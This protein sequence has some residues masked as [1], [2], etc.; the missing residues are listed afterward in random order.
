[1]SGIE[2]RNVHFSYGDKCIWE[3]LDVIFPEG[4]IAVLMAPSGRGK[5]TLLFL[6]A[7]LV[8]PRAGTIVYPGEHM[9]CSMVFQD[10]RLVAGLSVQQNIRLVN[11]QISTE[12]LSDCLR[13]MCLAG[14]EKK[15]VSHLSGGEKQRVA[16]ARALLAEYDLLLLD[17]PFTGLDDEVKE[18]V[19]EVIKTR[20]QGKTV[21]LVTHDRQE[22]TLIGGQIYDKF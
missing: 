14:Y 6:V 13:E 18:R 4:Q 9:R 17:E 22:A 5:T 3:G 1:M 20:S 11:P 2:F 21:L 16:I 19:I 8:Q 7:G 10:V 12:Q 15:K